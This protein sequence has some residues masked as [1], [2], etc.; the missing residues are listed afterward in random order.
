MVARMFGNC[1]STSGLN[2]A[3]VIGSDVEVEAVKTPPFEVG[4][5]EKGQHAL[6]TCGRWMSGC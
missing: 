4:T 2:F 5:V 1:F 3:T 6:D